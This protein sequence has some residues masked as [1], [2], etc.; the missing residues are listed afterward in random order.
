LLL[1]ATGMRS[2]R[3]D[4]SNWPISD[5]SVIIDI[6]EMTTKV[7]LLN[8]FTS[9]EQAFRFERFGMIKSQASACSTATSP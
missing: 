4:V 7:F 2:A 9:F 5:A 6:S 3:S 1:M 8:H